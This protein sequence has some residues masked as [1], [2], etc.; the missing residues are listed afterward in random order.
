[1]T[2]ILGTAGLST[3][4]GVL[5]RHTLGVEEAISIVHLAEQVGFTGVDTAPA[6]G[7][8]EEIV[9]VSGTKLA[10]HTKLSKGADPKS[11]ILKSLKLLRCEEVEVIYLHHSPEIL[12]P[13]S[14]QLAKAFELVGNKAKQLGLSVYSESEFEA[15]VE[16]ERISVIQFPANLLDRRFLGESLE[17]ALSRNKRMIVRSVFLQGVLLARPADVPSHLSELRES[18][19]QIEDIATT[20]GLKRD[21]ILIR[22]LQQQARQCE[23]IIGVTSLSDL[24]L[25]RDLELSRDLPV[26]VTDLLDRLNLPPTL[27]VDPRTW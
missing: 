17:Y 3:P 6:Y 20:F 5:K 15:A 24:A 10:V 23:I 8:A 14:E 22:W 7:D 4:Y 26:E 25:Y 9:G 19:V 12:D 18:L 13:R 2:F 16:D 1:M 27:L 11:S 21:Q